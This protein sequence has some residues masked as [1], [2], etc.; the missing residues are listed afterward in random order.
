M[1]VPGKIN[2]EKVLV[3]VGTGYYVEKVDLPNPCGVVWCG[4]DSHFHQ[5]REGAG[6]FFQRKIDYVTSNLEK[7]QQILIDKHKLKESKLIN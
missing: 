1:Y 6:K 7:M 2:T 4:G 3:D 5:D